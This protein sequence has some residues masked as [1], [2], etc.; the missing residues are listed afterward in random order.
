MYNRDINRRVDNRRI[1]TGVTSVVKLKV[2][3]N[4]HQD[5]RMRRLAR[6]SIS[7][8]A[9]RSQGV[10]DFCSELDYAEISLEKTFAPK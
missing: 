7:I 1:K 10:F 2:G 4:L 6:K 3:T 9:F 5:Y 8:G